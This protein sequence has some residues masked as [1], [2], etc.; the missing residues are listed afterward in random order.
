MGIE[1]LVTEDFASMSE[2]RGGNR[3]G[4]DPADTQTEAGDRSGTCD[5]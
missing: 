4:K 3:Q 1:I 2:G 5:G